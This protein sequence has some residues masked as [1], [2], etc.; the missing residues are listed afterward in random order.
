MHEAIQLAIFKLACSLL[1]EDSISMTSETNT[2]HTIKLLRVIQLRNTKVRIMMLHLLTS[3][4]P[5]FL[6]NI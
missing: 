1:K 5:V 4:I 2:W 3:Q 6:Q